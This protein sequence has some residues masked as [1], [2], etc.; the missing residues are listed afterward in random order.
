MSST[1]DQQ[2]LEQAFLSARTHHAFQ[3]QRPVDEATL[4]QLY[5]LLKWAP[6]SMNSQPGRF[7]F[8][9]SPAAKARLLPLVAEGNR[10]QTEQAPVTVIV[11]YDTQFY[12]HLPEQF[13]VK[14]DAREMFADSPASAEENAFRN[15]SLQ[16]GYL[17]LAARL[18]GLDCGPMSGFDRAGVDAEFFPEGR[19]RSN[20]L[21]NLGYGDADKLYPRGPRLDF[22]TATRVL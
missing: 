18:L 5:E 17:I 3:P 20:F 22:E 1:V 13:P 6:T 21:V 7:V 10:A 4:R 9:T 15:G 2:A 12:E 16:G 8:V 11:A 19:W 14:A